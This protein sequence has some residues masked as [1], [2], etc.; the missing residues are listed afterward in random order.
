MFEE[1]H[2]RIKNNKTMEDKENRVERTDVRMEKA[3]L[4]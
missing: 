4:I 2:V 3:A 1:N